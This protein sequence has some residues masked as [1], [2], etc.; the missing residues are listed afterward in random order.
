MKYALRYGQRTYP[1]EEG[2]HIIGRGEECALRLD[3]PLASRLHAAV[4]VADQSV[5]LEDLQSRNGVYVNQEK[6]EK[7][8]EL[9]HGDAV[10]IGSQEMLF[11]RQR[12]ALGTETLVEGKVRFSSPGLDV[13]SGLADKALSLGRGEEAERIV[14]RH[15]EKFLARAEEGH[16]LLAADFELVSQ[17]ALK[18]G[19]L[20][21]RGKW[22][23]FLFRLYAAHKK[24]MTAETVHELYSIASKAS[25]TTISSLDAYIEV[26]EVTAV[27]YSPAE[28]FALRRIIG[29]R[30]LVA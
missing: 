21:G 8:R 9:A 1:L 5:R 28:R 15:L 16:K 6:V 4:V 13:L 20:T 25:G 10:R 7:V 23:D 18:I 27:N 11:L 24:I 3:D 2:R 22:L 14:G 12:R 17:C 29:L 26:L 30:S 19:A